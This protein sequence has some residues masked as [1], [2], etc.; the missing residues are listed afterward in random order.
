MAE[1][2][3]PL[4]LYKLLKKSNCGE[5]RV[6]SCMAFAVAVVQGQKTLADCPYLDEDTVAAVGGRVVRHKSFAEEQVKSLQD[7]QQKI[8]ST[9][10]AAAAGRLGA[11]LAG[12]RLAIPC[13]GKEFLIAP[14]G[15][16]A[17]PCHVNFW[18]HYPLLNYVLRC[19]GAV[20]TGEWIGMGELKEGGDWDQFFSHRVEEAMRQLA[21]AHTELFFEML[22]VFGAGPLAG[23]SSADYSLV[24]RPL[25]KVPFLLNY[26]AQEEGI[27]SKLNILFDRSASRNI[28][29]GSIFYLGGGLVEMFRQLIVRH[30]RDGKL[31]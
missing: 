19:Q 12:G 17:S 23:G 13:L 16:M 20:L 31:F 29:P 22:E 25:P 6:P 26:W 3:N 2:K 18:V 11:T 1:L 24:L 4:E 9:D 27:D 7:L 14:D 15:T 28:D 10:F 8:R 30:S 21:D 5:C